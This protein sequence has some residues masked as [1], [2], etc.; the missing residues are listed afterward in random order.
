MLRQVTGEDLIAKDFKMNLNCYKEYTRVCSKQCLGRDSSLS[1]DEVSENETRTANNFKTVCSF[2]MDHVI[3]GH[4]SVSIKVLTEMYGFDKEDSRLHSK[5]NQRIENEFGGKIAFVCIGYHE[6][7][8]VINHS[9]LEDTCVSNFIKENKK[10]ILKESARHLRSDITE[11]ISKVP[12]LPWPP[13]TQALL[14]PDRQP[15]KSVKYFLDLCF[16]QHIIHLEMMSVGML[17]H[18]PKILFMLYQGVTS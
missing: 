18:F 5:V 10:F 6:L 4:Q 7:Q 3:G 14:W 2:I 8:I 1:V 11:L 16:I 9:V 15:P 13:T 12:E 17:S